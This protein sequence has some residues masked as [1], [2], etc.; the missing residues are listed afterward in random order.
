[1]RTTLDLLL[2][3]EDKHFLLMQNLINFRSFQDYTR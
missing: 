3:T 2:F 1:M